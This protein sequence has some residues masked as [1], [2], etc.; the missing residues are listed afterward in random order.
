MKHLLL[1]LIVLST[2]YFTNCLEKEPCEEDNFGWVEVSNTSVFTY[3]I[4]ING[5]DMGSVLSGGT[6]DFKIPASRIAYVVAERSS[7]ISSTVEK[8]I[9]VLACETTMLKI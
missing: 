9:G 2:L 4:K 5:K 6:R 3:S 1:V 8:T 7:M